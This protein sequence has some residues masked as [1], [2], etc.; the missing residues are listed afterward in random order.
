MRVARDYL[1]EVLREL[2]RGSQVEYEGLGVRLTIPCKHGHD[3][4]VILGKRF[5][6]ALRALFLRN[7]IDAP[8]GFSQ[9][10]RAW[11]ETNSTAPYMVCADRCYFEDEADLLTFLLNFK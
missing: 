1:D 4:T 10:Q 8:Y 6:D 5:P 7:I 3:E 2:P 9:E 11:L